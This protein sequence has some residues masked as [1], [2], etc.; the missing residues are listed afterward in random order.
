MQIDQNFYLKTPENDDHLDQELFVEKDEGDDYARSDKDMP[1]ENQ[2]QV[3]QN[4]VH[5]SSTQR[6]IDVE[7]FSL[8]YGPTKTLGDFACYSERFLQPIP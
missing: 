8:Q 5:W 4:A 3:P 1:T 7:N 6:E 2:S